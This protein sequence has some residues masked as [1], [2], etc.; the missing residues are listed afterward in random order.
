[1]VAIGDVNLSAA[2]NFRLSGDHFPANMV[3]LG[4]GKLCWMVTRGNSASYRWCKRTFGTAITAQALIVFF[5]KRFTTLVIPV[6]MYTLCVGSNWKGLTVAER[7]EKGLPESELAKG[8]I[9]CLLAFPS[10][11]PRLESLLTGKN[12]ERAC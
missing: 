9:L 10:P 6:K 4:P 11:H 7:A 12:V 3:I 2:R 8:G 1:M 5:F